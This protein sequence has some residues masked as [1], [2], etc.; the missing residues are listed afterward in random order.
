MAKEYRTPAEIL[1]AAAGVPAA[2]QPDQNTIKAD[3]AVSSVNNYTAPHIPP[4]VNIKDLDPAKAAEIEQSLKDMQDFAKGQVNPDSPAIVAA[5]V[6]CPNCGFN[7]QAEPCPVTEEDKR[8]FMRTLLTKSRFTKTFKLFDGS[9]NV[10]FANRLT[11][12][13]NLITQ[14]LTQE[15]VDRR[16]LLVDAN[17]AASNYMYRQRRLQMTASLQRV[18][19][20]LIDLTLP[21]FTTPH[22]AELYPPTATDNPLAVASKSVYED[23]PEVLYGAIFRVFA[24]FENLTLRLMENSRSPDFWKGIAGP[25]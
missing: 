14:Q 7:V 20:G 17:L 8:N 13:E 6:F 1:A 16:L 18:H 3:P 10:T 22:A 9:I 25:V 11:K 5:A 23:W 12:L 4:V 21:D 15:I 24:E 19:A 2:P